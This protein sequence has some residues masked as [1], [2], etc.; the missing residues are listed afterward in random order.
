M[1]L[2]AGTRG[3]SAFAL[4]FDLPQQ[5]HFDERFRIE[6]LFHP[7]LFAQ[8]FPEG[9]HRASCQV[10]IVRK[11]FDHRLITRG[12]DAFVILAVNLLQKSSGSFR[13]RFGELNH[14]G[15][16]AQKSLDVFAVSEYRIQN[17]E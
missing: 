13:L 11:N 6:R 17:A 1:P 3:G 4:A 5:T 9:V 7:A 2:R 10:R 15:H 14:V 16:A 12:D 8:D